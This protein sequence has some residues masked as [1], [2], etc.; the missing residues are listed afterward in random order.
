MNKTQLRA[1]IAVL[2][3]QNNDLKFQLDAANMNVIHTEE[4]RMKYLADYWK[5]KN[6]QHQ[7][8]MDMKGQAFDLVCKI[9]EI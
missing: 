7:A 5:V 2:E 4:E 8:I 3:T 6:E 1:R 9:M